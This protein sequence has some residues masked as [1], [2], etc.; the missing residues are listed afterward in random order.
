MTD[1]P[2]PA[3]PRILADAGERHFSHSETNKAANIS[4]FSP[5]SM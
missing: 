3:Q 2:L 1:R 5:F 4:G